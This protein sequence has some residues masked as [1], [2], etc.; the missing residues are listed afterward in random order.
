MKKKLVVEIAEGLGNQ[1]FMYAFAYSFSKQMNYELF[2]D[3]KSGYFKKKNQLRTLQK[4]I[5]NNFNLE[6]RIAE[7]N[8]IYNSALKI[9]K[10]KIFLFIDKFSNKKKFLLEKKFKINGSKI[11]EEFIDIKKMIYSDNLYIQGNFE[12]YLYFKNYKNELQKMFRPKYELLDVNKSLIEKLKNT[13]SVSIHI[14]RNRFSDQLNLKNE[15]NLRKSERFTLD[16]I[17]YINKSIPIVNSNIQNPEYFIWTNDFDN[18]NFYLNK[19]QIQNYTLI[20]NNV[21][22]DFNLFN[23]CKHFIVGPSSFHWWGAWLNEHKNKICLR[24]SNMNPSN[25]PNF[26]PPDWIKV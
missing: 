10:K 24:P 13:N 4:Y 3:N 26:W 25:N 8:L 5:L 7:E 21:I 15:K 2:I 20:K 18:I 22:N 1:L 11:A 23:Y 6:G 14:R 9:L 12:N 16:I 19:L 17:D